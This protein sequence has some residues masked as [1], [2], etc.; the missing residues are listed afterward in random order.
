MTTYSVDEERRRVVIE[1]Q[2]HFDSADARDVIERVRA[3][4]VWSYECL[5]DLTLATLDLA[6]PEVDAIRRL[7]LAY[8]TTLAPRG[9]IAVVAPDRDAYWKACRYAAFTRRVFRVQVFHDRDEAES[10]L[11]QA[12]RG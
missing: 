12:T 10:W 5:Y 2:G 8:A 6:N 9:P 4:G 1:V 7:T 3:D 11:T